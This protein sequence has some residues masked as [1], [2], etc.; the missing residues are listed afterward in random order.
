MALAADVQ[1]RGGKHM[2]A[3]QVADG[4]VFLRTMMVNLFIIREADSWI[5]V[6]A[7][8]SGYAESL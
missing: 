7:G 1:T 5:L 2:R 4:V 6:D 8:L 3:R